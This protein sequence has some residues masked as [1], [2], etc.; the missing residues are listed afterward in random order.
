MAGIT[1]EAD[2]SKTSQAIKMNLTYRS[3][4]HP[5]DNVHSTIINFQ[6]LVICRCTILDKNVVHFSLLVSLCSLC[7]SHG[8]QLAAGPGCYSQAKCSTVANAIAK[9]HSPLFQFVCL[10][11]APNS[12]LAQCMWGLSHILVG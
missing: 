11:F 2:S 4:S 3:I 8:G 5:L 1:L 9:G 10:Q 6:A 12:N 7:L